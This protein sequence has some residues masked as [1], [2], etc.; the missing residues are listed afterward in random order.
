MVTA[1]QIRMLLQHP[2]R[3]VPADPGH[4][5][6]CAGAPG[7][8]LG[9]ATGVSPG[10]TPAPR[11]EA[12]TQ[13]KL[14]LAPSAHWPAPAWH[15]GAPEPAVT[16][17]PSRCRPDGPGRAQVAL[18]GVVGDQPPVPEQRPCPRGMLE[19]LVSVGGSLLLISAFLLCTRAR[20]H[21]HPGARGG[22]IRHPEYD[23]HLT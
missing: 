2:T 20:V 5:D 6:G 21:A 22:R 3:A 9:A 18:S 14:S 13:G 12:G 10:L 8:V 1:F 17:A 15:A 11:T 4:G 23:V 7:P 19:E 16:Q